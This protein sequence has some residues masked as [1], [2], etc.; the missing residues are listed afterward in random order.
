[1]LDNLLDLT[2]FARVVGTG[3]QT[4]AAR[5]LDLSLAV[6]SKRLAALEQRLAVRLLNRTTRKQSLTQEGTRFHQ[7]CVRILSE[8]HDAES[9]MAQS[10]ETVSGLLRITA[11]RAFGRRYVTGIAARFQ[12]MH[13]ALRVELNLNDEI[14]D[15]VETGIDVALRFGALQDSTMTARFVAPGYRVLCASPDYV[16]RHGNPANPAALLD[17]QCIVYGAHVSKHW[18][19][20]HNGAPVAAEI[21]ATFLCNDGD[22]A[23]ALA[24]EGAG[25]FFKSIWDVGADLAAG[26][27]VQV[28]QGYRAPTEPL[29]VVYPHALHL[30]PRVRE[31]SDYAV[32]QLRHAWGASIQARVDGSGDAVDLSPVLLTHP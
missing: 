11:P 15:L 16:R 12:A 30:S 9:D 3:S 8:V 2:I 31:F 18:L 32:A 17:H 26:R 23:Q 10:R 27:L 22:A 6:V 1:M 25:I 19:L 29:H 4:D 28:M 13:R 14:V 5:E 7:H 20:H 21:Q 24:L